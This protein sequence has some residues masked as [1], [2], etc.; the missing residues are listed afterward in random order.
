M[1]IQ[2]RLLL[3]SILFGSSIY[4]QGQI[5]D[6]ECSIDYIYTK[7]RGVESR[8]VSFEN[9]KDLKGNANIENKGAKAHAFERT[10]FYAR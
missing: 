7:V 3:I 5:K 6:P 1:N 4:T 10:R 2:I 8:V 9:S